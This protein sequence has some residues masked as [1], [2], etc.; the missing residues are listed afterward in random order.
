MAT[1]A[2]ILQQRRDATIEEINNNTSYSEDIKRKL[3]ANQV[4]IF[5]I[6]DRL[7]SGGIISI[8]EIKSIVNNQISIAE[9]TK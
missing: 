9:Q 2:Q 4:C 7:S 1:V 6:C 5:E 3:V 8:N